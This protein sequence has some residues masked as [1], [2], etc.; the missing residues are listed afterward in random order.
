M[1]LSIPQQSSIDDLIS[2]LGQPVKRH[3]YINYSRYPNVV[4]KVIQILKAHR[5]GDI[6]KINK[7]T[8]FKIRTL[9]NWKKALR[10]NPDFNP[11]EKKCG[12][13]RR[14][15]TDEEEDAIS[16]YIIE[17]ILLAGVLFTDEDF[18]ELIMQAFLEKHRDD[19]E[20]AELPSFNASHGFIY[21]F[22]KN[23]GITQVYS[24]AALKRISI[25]CP[26][27]VGYFK[28]HAAMG[29]SDF[30]KDY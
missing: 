5:R 20:D 14:I 30:Y 2:E 18:E 16:D 25:F 24:I 7:H 29:E 11:L 4:E 9:Y 28:E 10:E 21:D 26:L 1:T 23:H 12:Q 8:Q 17:N 27:F 19:P 3:P 6:Q 15:F 13:H 22:K